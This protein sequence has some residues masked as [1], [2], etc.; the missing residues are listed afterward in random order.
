MGLIAI[1]SELQPE[2][3]S[4]TIS[5]PTL[6]MISGAFLPDTKALPQ[7]GPR[8]YTATDSGREDIHESCTNFP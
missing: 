8:C 4:Q 6:S 1:W 7:S 5:A 3:K 2:V